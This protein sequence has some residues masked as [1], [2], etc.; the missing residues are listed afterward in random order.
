MAGGADAQ[1]QAPLEKTWEDRPVRIDETLP[2]VEVEP[3]LVIDVGGF[4]GPLD[5]CCISPAIRKSISPAFLGAGAGRTISGV[6]RKRP[7]RPAGACGGLSGHGRLACLSQSR[8]L[9]PQAPKDDGPS[10]EE[11]AGDARLS[12]PAARSDPRRG[13]AAGQSQPAGPGLLRPRRAGIHP[14]RAKVC[15]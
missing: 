12:P 9:I 8:L 4:E 6:H 13:H 10:G 11:M 2:A 7:P 1:E 3:A 15:L 5:C 14:G